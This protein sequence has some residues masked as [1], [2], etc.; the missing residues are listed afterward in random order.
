MG[1]TKHEQ[2]GCLMAKEKGK[3][4]GEMNLSQMKTICLELGLSVDGDHFPYVYGF[5]MN[6]LVLP[7]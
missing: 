1:G 7:Q 3:E 6:T 2:I 4:V 5:S